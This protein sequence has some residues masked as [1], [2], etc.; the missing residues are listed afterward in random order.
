M[1]IG[2]VIL[3]Y[4][5]WFDTVE[6]IDSLEKQTNQSFKIV[7]VDNASNNESFE[8]L[9]ERYGY[10]DAIHL[11]QTEENLGFAK[12][13]NTGIMYCKKEL[14]LENILVINND[15][16][17]T[18]ENYIEK[19]THMEIAKDIGVIGTKIIGADGEN[20]NPVYFTPSKKAVFREF[21]IPLLRKYHLAG[22][23]DIGRILKKMIKKNTQPSSTTSTGNRPY[24][25]HGSV[26]FLTQNYLSQ[27][28]GLYPETFLYYEEEILGLVC[29]KLHLKMIY[30]DEIEIYHKEDQSSKL[31]FQNLEGIK[32]KFARRSVRI[33]LKVSGMSVGKILKVMNNQTYKFIRFKQGN[34]VVYTYQ[35]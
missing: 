28:N 32:Q 23:L 25:L 33:G 4:L 16:I 8:K 5:N 30:S 3:N 29:K 12:G 26:I 19:L 17:F 9:S 18:D 27:A 13:N 24:I 2:I 31:S 35:A 11:L 21:S 14:G 1:E 6:C 20:Q 15:V 34:E 10:E 22:I 7:I